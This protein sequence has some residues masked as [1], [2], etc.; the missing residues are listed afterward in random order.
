MNID[1]LIAIGAGVW[2]KNSRR[3]PPFD[4]IKGSGQRYWEEQLMIRPEPTKINDWYNSFKDYLENFSVGSEIFSK[5][6]CNVLL[7]AG[8][9]DQNAL[10]QTVIVAYE[11]IQNCQLSIIPNSGHEV[12]SHR[13][14]H[15]WPIRK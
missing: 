8:D 9:K 10:L 6:T 4:V 14:K 15:I 11:M 5:I 2:P 12:V 7:M 13:F 1:K 3:F